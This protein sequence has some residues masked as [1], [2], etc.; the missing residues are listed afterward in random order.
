MDL[1][2]YIYQ[3]KL[4]EDLQFQNSLPVRADVNDIWKI[5][6][7]ISDGVAF[8]HNHMEIHRDIK[9][10]NSTLLHSIF[11]TSKFYISLSRSFGRLQILASR[12]KQ[13]PRQ[14][15]GLNIQEEHPAIERQNLLPRFQHSATKLT[16]GVW[17][18]SS[19]SSS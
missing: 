17:D 2:Q 4:D 12:Q 9:P 10:T 7:D 13:R 16:F 3:V 6:R 8:I 19:M 14:R 15:C 5:M 1:N 11:L 18:V